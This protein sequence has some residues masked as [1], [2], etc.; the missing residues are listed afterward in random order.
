M[1]TQARW[2]I[3][4]ALLHLLGALSVAGVRAAQGI[5]GLPGD[6][7]ALWL[8]QVHLLTVGWITQLIFGVAYWLFPRPRD[9]LDPRWDR[10]IWIGYGALNAGL[11]VRVVVEPGGFPAWTQTWG[12]GL[13]AGLQWVAGLCFVVHF[14]MR[15]QTK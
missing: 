13:S 10:A 5:G 6:P 12:F 1:P 4:T 7:A 3:K 14:W 15:V 8:P 11:L 2:L 9:G